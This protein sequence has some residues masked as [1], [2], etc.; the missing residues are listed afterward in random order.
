M[1]ENDRL[2]VLGEVGDLVEPM[3]VV[4]AY[5]VGENQRLASPLHFVVQAEA[6][7]LNRCHLLLP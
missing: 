2:I 1:I 3:R 5:S 4:T 6:V 7:D